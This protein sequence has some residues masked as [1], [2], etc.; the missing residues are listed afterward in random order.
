MDELTLRRGEECTQRA[1]INSDKK[2]E[3]GRGEPPLVNEEW[4]AIC[5]AI[6]R[7]VEGAEREKFI[8]MN[9]EVNVRH[10]GG[11]TM[12][13]V[14]GKM[15]NARDGTRD[16]QTY[17]TKIDRGEEVQQELWS[18]VR[19][20][21]CRKRCGE[22]RWE[23]TLALRRQ[24][25][26]GRDLVVVCLLP[27]SQVSFFFIRQEAAPSPETRLSHRGWAATVEWDVVEDV[28]CI[29]QMSG[30]D[31]FFGYSRGECYLTDG[32]ALVLACL[33]AGPHRPRHLSPSKL[34][35]RVG[36]DQNFKSS[37]CSRGTFMRNEE[38]MKLRPHSQNQHVFMLTV[39]HVVQT[40][41]AERNEV[42][43]V[44]RAK[45]TKTGGVTG[46][47]QAANLALWIGVG[48][49][50]TFQGDV[51]PGGSPLHGHVGGCFEG[52]RQRYGQD[53][54]RSSVQHRPEVHRS[55]GWSAH[56][57]R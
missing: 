34:K 25:G 42:V 49:Q 29:L 16:D 48:H 10:P 13:K 26:A 55:S 11:R 46:R 36:Q 45:S 14:L 9:Q 12:A 8:E 39:T 44:C 1:F 2:V 47:T 38:K 54:P 41:V 15:R 57:S 37:I 4:H 35:H 21:P 33:Q 23:T 50:A 20:L 22:W 52:A 32:P 28:L 56:E 31:F 43:F 18:G 7:G 5:Q 24:E 27:L 51:V 53:V 6:N 30:E 40:S 17:A 3:A 19:R